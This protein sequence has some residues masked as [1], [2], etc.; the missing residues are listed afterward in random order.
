MRRWIWEQ[1]NNREDYRET[2]AHVLSTLNGWTKREP[3]L[4]QNPLF[5][6]LHHP[7]YLQ[8]VRQVNAEPCKNTKLCLVLIPGKRNL[9]IICFRFPAALVSMCCRH[10]L[11]LRK[12]LKVFY[13]VRLGLDSEELS[14]CGVKPQMLKRDLTHVHADKLWTRMTDRF[15]AWFHSISPFR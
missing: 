3:T 11:Q 14:V 4:S 5:F 12:H 10:S 7:L 13:M 15:I 9:M 8:S 6:L 1:K 2:E